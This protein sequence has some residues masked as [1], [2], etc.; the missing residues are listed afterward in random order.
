MADSIPSIAAEAVLVKSIEI[1]EGTPVVQG[2]QWTDDGV[3]D[4]DKLLGSYL[5]SGFQ[6]TNFGNAVQEV[7]K[8]V[9]GPREDEYLCKY[10]ILTRDITCTF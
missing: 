10:P 7:T 8:M 2:Y 5:N 4:Y 6:A 9:S 3:V 1:P